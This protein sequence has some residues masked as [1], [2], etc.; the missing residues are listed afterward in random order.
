[1]WIRHA[2]KRNARVIQLNGPKSSV[3]LY[4]IDFVSRHLKVLKLSFAC[5]YDTNFRQLSS[6]CPCLEELES[7][8][9]F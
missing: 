6:G 3:G 1:M 7:T 4:R 8:S 5:V 9:K 2:I